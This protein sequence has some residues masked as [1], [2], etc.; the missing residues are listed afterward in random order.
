MSNRTI[1][2]FFGQA[3]PAKTVTTDLSQSK[4]KR[5][6]ST[7]RVREFKPKWRLEYPWL[8][9]DSEEDRDKMF[10]TFCAKYPTLAQRN[11]FV[12]GTTCFRKSNIQAH[13]ISKPHLECERRHIHSIQSDQI[14]TAFST[15]I[16]F[17]ETPIGQGVKRMAEADRLKFVP[18]FNT[19]FTLAKHAKAFNDM[20]LLCNLQEKNGVNFPLGNNYRNHVRAK[21]FV[22]SIADTI[23]TDLKADIKE[24][25]FVSLLAD[26]STDTSISEQ[27]NVYIRYFAKGRIV[28]SLVDIVELESSNAAGVFSGIEKALNK[29]DLS[30]NVLSN[31]NDETPTIV[32]ANFDGASVM[33]GQKG[34]T[35]A[36]I[37]AKAPWIIPMHCVA[38]KL[39]LAALDA[40]K[41]VTYLQK[42]EDTIKGI[43]LF[44][45]YSPKCRRE[46]KE[47]AEILQEDLVYI[48]SLKQVYNSKIYIE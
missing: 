47:I 4:D 6:D 44:Y 14:H 35:M 7:K 32:C 26:G 18:L 16:K 13:T 3:G 48:S 15:R 1:I 17:A 12:G 30:M 8:R 22:T 40:S 11:A 25:N 39:E 19:A 42:F 38:H 46:V 34:G 24:A 5:Y 33:Q 37:L 23:K 21:E 41:S 43:F 2:D 45:H 31:F 9:Y 27:E 28:T 20:E 36:H 29:V 10:C